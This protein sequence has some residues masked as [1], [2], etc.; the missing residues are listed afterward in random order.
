[1]CLSG[2]AL[3]GAGC[4]AVWAAVKFKVDLGALPRCGLEWVSDVGGGRG[5]VLLLLDLWS[6]ASEIEGVELSGG[7][8]TS[9]V[10]NLH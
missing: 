8:L 5:D 9:S 4:L 6:D 7:G 2:S 10:N 3:C 1:M